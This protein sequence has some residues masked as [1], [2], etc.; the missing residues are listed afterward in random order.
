MDIDYLKNCHNEKN[1]PRDNRNPRI[2]RNLS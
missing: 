2:P 1:A